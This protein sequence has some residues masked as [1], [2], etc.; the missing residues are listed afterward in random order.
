MAEE[1]SGAAARLVLVCD[2]EDTIRD[3]VC[4]ILGEAG[5]RTMTATD[6]A[7]V[8][9]LARQH[10]PVLIV[11]DV[12]MPRMD[13]YTTLMRLRGHPMTQDV[14]VVIL[15]G[16][17]DPMYRTLSEGIGAVAHL[18]KPFSPRQLLETV[19]RVLEGGAS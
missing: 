18:T 5:F 12:M 8:L 19:R 16:Q 10:E 13:G 4:E 3:L 11:L 6:G 9:D 15:T 14:P 7:E 1:T 2:D 17:S